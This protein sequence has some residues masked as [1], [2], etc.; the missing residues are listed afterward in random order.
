MSTASERVSET[1][2]EDQKPVKQDEA[3]RV[4]GTGSDLQNIE[5]RLIDYLQG[6]FELENLRHNNYLI[7]RLSRNLELHPTVIYSERSVINMCQDP[8]IIDAA[9]EKVKGIEYQAGS[10]IKLRLSSPRRTVIVKHISR[11]DEQQFKTFIED[12]LSAQNLEC[13]SNYDPKTETYSLTLVDE[14]SAVQVFGLLLSMKFNQKNIDCILKEDNLYL[15]LIEGIQNKKS[16]YQYSSYAKAQFPYGAPGYGFS[17]QPMPMYFMQYPSQIL[18]QN[19]IR[20]SK[21]S[22]RPSNNETSGRPSDST[23]ESSDQ[24]P[25][26][27]PQKRGYGQ[28]REYGNYYGQQRNGS[29]YRG[30]KTY[31]Q[32]KAYDN[33]PRSEE[34]EFND[35]VEENGRE[36]RNQHYRGGRDRQDHRYGY[37]KGGFKDQGYKY[38]RNYKKGPS[39]AEIEK[40]TKVDLDNYPPLD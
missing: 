12:L 14:T 22:Y 24:S 25:T 27:S 39:E 28:Y 3:E 35:Q 1:S 2:Y 6:L 20:K 10:A 31:Y 9:L 30:N 36:F 40:V 19:Y 26:G 18:G 17:S 13:Q 15:E 5:S 4:E 16:Q 37:Q 33:A 11:I 29:G 21:E 8:S 32:K 38:P 23:Y 7:H 34:E